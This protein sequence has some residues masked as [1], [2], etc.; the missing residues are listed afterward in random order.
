MKIHSIDRDLLSKPSRYA[1]IMSALAPQNINA[2]NT[3]YQLARQQL[4]LKTPAYTPSLLPV[5]LDTAQSLLLLYKHNNSQTHYLKL[6]CS[7]LN[8]LSSQTTIPH[9]Q[10]EMIRRARWILSSSIALSSLSDSIYNELYRQVDL[11]F[12]LPLSL[13][14]ELKGPD[15]LAL[16]NHFFLKWSISPF[17]HNSKYDDA[18]LVAPSLH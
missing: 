18:F 6:V 8:K 4:Y 15:G 1:I 9:Q 3:Y 5:R 11:P 14:K 2:S 7:L 16:I 13:S 10:P 17:P 12:N